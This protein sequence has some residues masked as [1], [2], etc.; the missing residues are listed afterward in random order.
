MSETESDPFVL[1][2]EIKKEREEGKMD[3]LFKRLTL[4]ALGRK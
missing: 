1:L 4:A 3:L 2:Q